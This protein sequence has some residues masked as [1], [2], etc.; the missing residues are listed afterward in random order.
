M[1]KVKYTYTDNDGNAHFSNGGYIIGHD[2]LDIQD[3]ELYHNEGYDENI[4][5]VYLNTGLTSYTGINDLKNYLN[6]TFN[7]QNQDVIDR[8]VSQI[9]TTAT[10]G[11][12]A[13]PYQF[14]PS[15]DRRLSNEINVGRKYSE[16]IFSRLPLLFLTPCE[17]LFMGQYSE[18]AKKL[19]LE[20][21]LLGGEMS[22]FQQLFDQESKDI[23]GRYY[24][25]Q[26]NYAE[27]YNYLNLMLAAVAAYLGIYDKEIIMSYDGK[28]HKVGTIA[29]QNELNDA[30][31]T[32][33]SASE[34]IV[35]YLDGME[36]VSE[37]FSNSTMESSIASQINGYSE[38]A[39]EVRYLFGGA[40]SEFNSF[41][42]S[43]AQ[44]T[45]NIV[46]GLADSILG[47]GG[48]IVKSLSGMGV[49]T[50]LNGGKIIFPKLWS[51]SEYSRSYNIDIKLR[52]PDHDSLSIFLNV[53]KPYCK[54]IALTLPR[55]GNWK[56]ELDPNSYW[57]PFLV[58][59]Y[60]KGLFNVDMGIITSMNVTKGAQC[61]WNDDGLPTQIDIQLEIE[62]LYSHM[63]M[64]TFNWLSPVKTIKG[65][66]NNTTYMDFLANMAGLNIAQM[67]IGRRISLAYYLVRTKV[68]TV[69]SSISTQ[70][71][72]AISRFLGHM[73]NIF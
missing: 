40:S 32:F 3:Y 27:Y 69:P 71:D 33:F 47:A 41:I 1:A 5:D 23:T 9:L 34:N 72:E 31:K 28:K 67:D 62:D 49:N 14:M 16:K 25:A 10:N 8:R 58:R 24:T 2:T 46:G 18:R 20:N 66:C 19:T 70:F 59:A 35:F 22:N 65:I 6:G 15:V 56:G 44:I 26:F 17:P 61:C 50:V 38:M 21:L 53:I 55:Q 54:L 12:E 37:S 64:S 73:Y 68:A 13:L 42:Q 60:S 4:A 7:T 11:I 30:F 48:G 36:S 57:S 63:A 51:D 39:K 29:W 52:S 45:E 43:G